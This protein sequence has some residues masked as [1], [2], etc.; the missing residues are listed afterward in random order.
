MDVNEYRRRNP[1]CRTCKHTAEAYYEWQCTAKNTRHRGHLG[2]TN[3]K[4]ILCALYQPK[5]DK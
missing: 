3:L 4:G 1:R 2:D 5:E